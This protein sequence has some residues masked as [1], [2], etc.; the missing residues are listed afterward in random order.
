MPIPSTACPAPRITKGR[1]SRAPQCRPARRRRLPQAI[2]A[3]ALINS[4]LIIISSGS[5]EDTPVPA[6]PPELDVSVGGGVAVVDRDDDGV[7]DGRVVGVVVEVDGVDV[8]GGMGAG[9]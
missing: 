9:M 1:T 6:S 8:G 7:V 5:D 4:T 2:A 3:P